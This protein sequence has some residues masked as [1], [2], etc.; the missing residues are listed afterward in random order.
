ML[1]CLLLF[2]GAVFGCLCVAA[3]FLVI[4]ASVIFVI[5]GKVVLG[6]SGA[7]NTLEFAKIKTTLT[8]AVALFALGAA[9]IALPFRRILQEE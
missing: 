7:P 5:K 4:V 3:G 2:T 9:L 8:S 1:A 6:E